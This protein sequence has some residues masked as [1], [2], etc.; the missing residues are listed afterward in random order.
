[1]TR[2]V[3]VVDDS[4]SVRQMMANTLKGAGFVVVTAADGQEALDVCGRLR[5][6]AVVTDQNM[7]R[8]DGIGFCRAFRTTPQNLGVPIIFLSTES[9]DAI[10]QKARAAGAIGWMIKPFDQAKLLAVINR[11][12][13]A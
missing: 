6:D 10:K 8:L 13:G 1:M 12:L 5:P 4:P 11:V 2:T 3:L 7:P 9:E